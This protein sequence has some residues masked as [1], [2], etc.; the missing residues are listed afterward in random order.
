MLSAVREIIHRLE[1]TISEQHF[2]H[3]CHMRVSC[4]SSRLDELQERLQALKIS[5]R[6]I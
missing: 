5:V 3:A 6:R 1:A 4:N 2:D